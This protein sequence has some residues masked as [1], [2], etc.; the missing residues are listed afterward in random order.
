[1]LEDR[2]AESLEKAGH[3]WRVEG[4]LVQPTAA[5]VRVML[6]WVASELYTR[7]VGT[8]LETGGLIFDKTEVGIHVSGTIGFYS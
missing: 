8:R 7:D 1:M 3:K 5:D 6:D 2:I 4:K